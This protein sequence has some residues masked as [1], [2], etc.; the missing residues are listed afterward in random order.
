L[1]L[2]FADLW[3]EKDGESLDIKRVLIIP[4]G[5]LSPPALQVFALIK[6][7]AFSIVDYCTGYAAVIGAIAALLSLHAL[8]KGENTLQDPTPGG[9]AQ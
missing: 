6:G 4:A 5:V 7:Q 8:S 3:T 2:K 9:P 1:T